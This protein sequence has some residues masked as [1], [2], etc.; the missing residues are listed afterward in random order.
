MTRPTDKWKGYHGPNADDGTPLYAH[1]YCHTC[2]RP[3]TRIEGRDQ[4]HVHD[5]T[6]ID[7]K[8]Y[9]S[10]DADFRV[11]I[12]DDEYSFDDYDA[13][14]DAMTDEERAVGQGLVKGD[15]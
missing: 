15:R 14:Y 7:P 2:S 8:P 13:D 11:T 4:S 5:G 3:L 1:G 9:M 6:L 10:V 12:H